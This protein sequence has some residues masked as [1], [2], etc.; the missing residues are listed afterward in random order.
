M[1]NYIPYKTMG[2]IN[3][4]FPNPSQTTLIIGALGWKN[5]SISRSP[6]RSNFSN[7][8]KTFTLIQCWFNIHW[9]SSYG[10][11]FN[12][13]LFKMIFNPCKKFLNYING[14]LDH[15]PINGKRRTHA[16]KLWP[17]MIVWIFYFMINISRR[18][19]LVTPYWIFV[20]IC[21]CCWCFD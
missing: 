2:V 15:N 4:P 3:Y 7:P 14:Y 12:I 9:P 16:M 19:V 8:S 10:K 6:H 5:T 1:S 21:L 18:R 17:S 20:M 13:L 11:L